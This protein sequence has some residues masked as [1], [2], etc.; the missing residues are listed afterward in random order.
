MGPH[1]ERIAND[2][3]TAVN[4]GA[5]GPMNMVAPNITASRAQ[6][7]DLAMSGSGRAAGAAAA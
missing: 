4:H 3:S 1:L 5:A 2:W 7:L 6:G